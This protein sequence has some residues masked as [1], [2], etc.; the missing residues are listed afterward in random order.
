MELQYKN[1]EFR[2]IYSLPNSVQKN[3]YLS[4]ARKTLGGVSNK[5]LR[6]EVS[7]YILIGLQSPAKSK[8]LSWEKPYAERDSKSRRFLAYQNNSM[9][10]RF[11]LYRHYFLLLGHGRCL[12][13]GKRKRCSGNR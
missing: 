7:L 5:R 2:G 9:A 12:N 13:L 1:K 3:Q 6:I 4:K 8:I 11:R 10:Y